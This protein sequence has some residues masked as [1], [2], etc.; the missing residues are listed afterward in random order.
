MGNE[1]C[2]PTETLPEPN[3]GIRRTETVVF[4]E[5]TVVAVGN[6]MD[7]KFAA[8]RSFRSDNKFMTGFCE[9]PYASLG[10]PHALRV[11]GESTK[12]SYLGLQRVI[13]LVPILVLHVLAA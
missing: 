6:T 8:L 5:E 1:W 12:H 2:A 4:D 11:L 3:Q 10:N 7:F 9:N 13:N